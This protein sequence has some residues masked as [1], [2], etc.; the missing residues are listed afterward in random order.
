[1][2]PMLDIQKRHAEIFRIRLGDTVLN[3][4]GKPTPRKLTDSIRVT[5]PNETV[6]RAF[7]EVFGGEPRP[8]N[9]Q[10]EVYLPTTELPVMILPGESIQQWWELWKARNE[11]VCDRRCDGFTETISGGP[12]ICSQKDGGDITVRLQT[13]GACRPMTRL[14]VVCPDVEVIGAG[15]LVTHGMIAAE[16]LPQSVK[17]AQA[18]LSRGL[19]VPAVFRVVEHKGRRHFIVPQ[20]EIV[21]VSLHQ[22]TTGEVSRLEVGNGNGAKALEPPAPAALPAPAPAPAKRTATEVALD[23]GSG[24]RRPAS[25]PA[26]PKRSGAEKAAASADVAAD[27]PADADPDDMTPAQNR[28]LHAMLSGAGIKS[29]EE[30]HKWA[31][32]TLGREV[33]TY[34][35]LSKSDASVLIDALRASEVGAK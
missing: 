28:M 21:G 23:T 13:A 11:A 16:T 14:S 35:V 22:L 1:M 18:A 33:T 12:C 30:R 24:P 32:E 19:M 26:L 8:W 10:H 34:S 25:K 20:L 6:V 15:S 31:S 29:D 2:S 5:S 27:P 17:V 7:A 3:K 9:G 4:D